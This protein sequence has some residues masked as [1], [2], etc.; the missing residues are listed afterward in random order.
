MSKEGI[1]ISLITGIISGILATIITNF[2]VIKKNE[3]KL[4]D[5]AI[6]IYSDYGMKVNKCLQRYNEAKDKK[7]ALKKV[8]DIIDDYPRH[9]GFK[10]TNSNILKEFRNIIDNIN[11]DITSDHNQLNAAKILD[12]CGK[13]Q[14][15]RLKMFETKYDF[16]YKFHN[17]P[18]NEY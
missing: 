11:F 5:E 14:N 17:E 18:V 10:Y 3:K 13:I 16:F 4:L 9:I 2:V 8:E 1:I 6:Q 12:Y 7:E 15:A